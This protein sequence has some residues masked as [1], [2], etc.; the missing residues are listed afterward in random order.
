MLS[1]GQACCEAAFLFIGSAMESCI[2]CCSSYAQLFNASECLVYCCRAGELETNTFEG[3]EMSKRIFQLLL[4]ACLVT[5]TD[6]DARQSASQLDAMT[7][8]A[9][10]CSSI[11][12]ARNS[13]QLP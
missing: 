6:F 11:P 13:V 8:S 12:I 3:D 5:G 4:A 1:N 9:G 10:T 2:E 7:G